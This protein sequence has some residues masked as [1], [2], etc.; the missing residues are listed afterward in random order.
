[1]KIVLRNNLYCILFIFLCL[2]S[3]CQKKIIP[4]YEEMLQKSIEEQKKEAF[5]VALDEYISKLSTEEKISQLFLV[6]IPGVDFTIPENVDDFLTPGGYLLFG[7][8]FTD[9]PERFINFT[10]D[11][12][13]WYI[14]NHFTPPYISVDH[15]GGLINRMRAIASPLPSQA[16]IAK[17]LSVDDAETVYYY[18]GLQMKDLGIHVNLAPVVEV[19]SDENIEFL[20]NRS[21]GDKIQ[22]K[23][24]SLAAIKGMKKAGIYPVVKHFPGNTSDDPHTGLPYINIPVEN[25]DELLF[26]PFEVAKNENTGVLV[27]HAVLTSVDDSPACLSKTVVNEILKNQIGVQGLLFSDDLYMKALT[28]NGYELPNSII[29]AINAGIDVIMLSVSSFSNC[30]PPLVKQYNKNEEFRER[31]LSSLKKILVWKIDNELLNYSELYSEGGK[32]IGNVELN[33]VAENKDEIINNKVLSFYEH[34]KLGK[35]LYQYYW[36]TN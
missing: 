14:E 25:V 22:S 36:G 20:G 18:A 24:Y 1:M 29:L 32:I 12:Y 2:F 9:S 33:H 15:E 7:F 19:L 27:G 11:I 4:Q 6:S 8:N 35:D 5:D 30:V 34:R 31:V 23:L 13:E 10:S 17:Y 16:S 21:Y 26:E 3:S 28:K